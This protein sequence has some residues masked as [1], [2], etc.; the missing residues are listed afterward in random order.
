MRSAAVAALAAALCAV[1]LAAC[2]A[3]AGVEELTVGGRFMWDQVVWGDV[4][5][6]LGPEAENGTEVRRARIFAKG[7]IYSRLG[8][9]VNWDFSDCKEIC[10]KDAYLELTGLP[11]DG[12]V[13]VGHMYE[14]FCLNELTSS[15]YITFMER[16]SLTAFAPSFNSGLIVM[17]HAG[18]R[19]LLSAGA[20][21]TTDDAGAASGDG[22]VSFGGRIAVLAAGEEKSD[23]VVHVGG[24]ANYL[25][26]EGGVLRF[27]A[28]PEV[29]MSDRLVDTGELHADSVLRLG[30]EAGAVLGPLHLAGEYVVASVAGLCDSTGE[31]GSS[32]AEDAG[33]SGLYA[34]AGYFLTGEHRSFADG[35]W[36]RVSPRHAF[37]EDGGLGAWELA[38]RY[39]SI[40]LND[41]DAGVEGRRMDCVTA[42]LNWYMH[43]NARIM[44]NQVW[45]TVKDA[46]D[47]DVGSTSATMIRYQFD[48]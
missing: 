35:Q 30:A 12:S 19:V 43:A 48:F 31:R 28:R 37:L 9:K 8:F 26:P 22:G 16:A 45:S 38:V 10:L 29:H 44:L 25:T 42:G 7:K 27:R 23:R 20:F 40:D 1:L 2:P 18:G 14:P 3:S 47:E 33:L 41:V 15:K 11:A 6:E 34:Q 4:D 17:G 5:E 36:Q 13:R 39:S 24:A 46:D 21:R 32:D